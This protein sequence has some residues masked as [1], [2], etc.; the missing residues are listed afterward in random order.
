MSRFILCAL[1]ACCALVGAPAFADRLEITSDYLID[2]SNIPP[3][4]PDNIISVRGD[5]VLTI[6]DTVEAS[7][8]GKI[9]MFDYSSL[10][11][12]SGKLRGKISLFG[13]HRIE[14]RGGK[15]DNVMT[16]NGNADVLIE[17]DMFLDTHFN[18]F[19]GTHTYEVRSFTPG[20]NPI[21][22][23]LDGDRLDAYTHAP[24][25]FAADT[26][27]KRIGVFCNPINFCGSLLTGGNP[28]GW[29]LHDT[30]GRPDGDSNL[31]GVVDIEDLNRVRNHFGAYYFHSDAPHGDTLPYDGV[32]NIEDLNRVRNNFGASIIAQSV[33]EPTTLTL[34]AL[35]TLGLACIAA[36]RR[37]WRT[38]RFAQS[39]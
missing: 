6:N 31:D 19:G 23:L 32:V 2:A 9:E 4:G 20:G 39:P 35:A 10:I 37:C 3:A 38:L 5:A 25:F 22:N 34:T 11:V 30:T 14:F 27:S 18:F 28:P 26:Y 15:H 8:I 33:P 24:Q 29:R 12:L 1:C 21:V 13:D 17:G 16:G 7:G 36:S